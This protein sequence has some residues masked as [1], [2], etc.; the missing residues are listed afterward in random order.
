MKRVENLENLFFTLNGICLENTKRWVLC[1]ALW[2]RG[3]SYSQCAWEFLLH[4]SSWH[5]VS[6]LLLGGGGWQRA[7]LQIAFCWSLSITWSMLS[8]PG[9]G[10][11]EVVPTECLLLFLT[12]A[13][14]LAEVVCGGPYFN[15]VEASHVE[16]NAWTG[17]LCLPV[18]NITWCLAALGDWKESMSFLLL[19][20]RKDISF[21]NSAFRYSAILTLQL[22]GSKALEISWLIISGY[23]HS[24]QILILF[25]K[26]KIKDSSLYRNIIT[27]WL[28]SLQLSLLSSLCWVADRKQMYHWSSASYNP[29]Q[30]FNQ[31]PEQALFQK[32]TNVPLK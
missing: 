29:G 4:F 21:S 1:P 15:Q 8:Q 16:L 22:S 28:I 27:V 13:K 25:E 18:Q 26:I 5:S 30:K 32:I 6:I 17:F 31:G 11:K 7:L 20:R 10:P 19:L 23:S 3:L 12:E 14:E 9:K 2:E 24:H